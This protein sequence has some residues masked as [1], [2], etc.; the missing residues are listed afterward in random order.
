MT[1]KIF[2]S[3]IS[4]FSLNAQ[5][6][7]PVEWEYDVNKINDT[8]R[9]VDYIWEKDDNAS[10][11]TVD[12]AVT[13]TLEHLLHTISQFGFPEVYPTELNSTS[14]T[15]LIWDAMQEAIANG[16]FNDQDYQPM[17]DG[18]NEFYSMV[19]REYVYL[20]TYAEWGYIT[21]FADGGT[22]APEWADNTR[23]SD[24][25]AINNP[26]GHSLY[27]DY[28]SKLI[29]KPSE[30]ILKEIFS[31]DAPSGYGTSDNFDMIVSTDSENVTISTNPND[32]EF[33]IS[34]KSYVLA[35]DPRTFSEASK[36]AE[37][38]GGDLVSV[39]DSFENLQIYQEIKQIID[40]NNLVAGTAS[41]GGGASY[42]WLGGSDSVAEGIWLWND[43]QIFDG[44]GWGGGSLG[45]EPDNFYNQD[46]LAMGLENWPAGS[47]DNE[48]YGNAGSWN[49]IQGSNMLFSVIEIA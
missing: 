11:Y 21:E 32:F 39:T 25:V 29:S 24:Q 48:G 7:E 20:L 40:I 9:N 43:G 38:L 3:F 13:E 31:V 18:S 44:F 28:I 26:L 34:G 10:D 36:Y 19:M 42:V 16:V 12:N 46:Y 22:L 30:I 33:S 5:D 27:T 49:D 17:N 35:S 23:S 15:G 1:R 45:S 8:T 37:S 6:I 14:P 2:F 47:L 4:I 41:D